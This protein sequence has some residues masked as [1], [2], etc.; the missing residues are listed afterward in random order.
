M[1]EQTKKELEVGDV[2]WL[3]LYKKLQSEIKELEE[4]AA[5]ARTH[6]ESALG[7]DEIGTFQGRPVVRWSRVVTNRFDTSA[8]KKIL[9]PAIYAFLSKESTSRRFTLVIEE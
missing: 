6:I 9:D 2:A 8:A 1:T 7:D 5:D 3:D 4:R